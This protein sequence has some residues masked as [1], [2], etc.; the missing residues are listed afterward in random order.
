MTLR[1]DVAKSSCCREM[2]NESGYS[3]YLERTRSKDALLALSA[4]A[5]LSGLNVGLLRAEPKSLDFIGKCP[6]L[7][8]TNRLTL[9][10][11]R[12]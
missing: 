2:H 11:I 1:Y 3:K 9:G 7:L 12:P 5:V 4:Y 10:N 6:T 8:K